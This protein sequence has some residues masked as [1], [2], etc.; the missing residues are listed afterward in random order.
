[1]TDPLNIML[2]ISLYGYLRL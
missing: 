1:M 2:T